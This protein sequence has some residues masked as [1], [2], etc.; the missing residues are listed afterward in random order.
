MKADERGFVLDASALLALLNS[1]PGG[2]VVADALP[3]SSISA[4]NWS[5]VLQ[6]SA[7]RGIETVNLADDLGALGMAIIPFDTETAANVAALW[8]AGVRSVA[9]AD[10]ACIATAQLAGLPAI[11]ADRSWLSLGLDVPIELI[12]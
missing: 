6:K 7:E 11:T 5:E 4:V 3:V 1:E 10:R 2:D 9:L 12:R 8:T